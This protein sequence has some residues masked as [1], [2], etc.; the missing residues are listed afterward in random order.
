MSSIILYPTFTKI[1]KYGWVD[2]TWK[3]SINEM[4]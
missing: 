3:A 2:E 4:R 1:L